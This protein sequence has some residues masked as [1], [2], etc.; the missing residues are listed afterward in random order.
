MSIHRTIG[1][2]RTGPI[3]ADAAEFGSLVF[4]TLHNLKRTGVP[5]LAIREAVRH[6]GL[7]KR[8]GP[9]MLAVA[10]AGPISVSEL[11]KRLGLLVSTTSTIV[12]ELSRAGLVERAEDENDR[13]RTIVYLNDAY[14]DGVDGWL[15]TAVIPI[16]ETLEQLTPEAREHF[17]QG[18]RILHGKAATAAAVSDHPTADCEP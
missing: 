12:G 14:R 2:S 4:E 17:M 15:Q 13:R 7:G 1:A 16:H 6:A 3:D 18:W 9:A 11:A 8:H 10:A 5:P